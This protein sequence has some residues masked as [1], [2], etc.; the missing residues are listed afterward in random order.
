[1]NIVCA[2][3]RVIHMW[4]TCR[5]LCDWLIGEVRDGDENFK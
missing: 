4:E 1:M 5:E 2:K 3:V